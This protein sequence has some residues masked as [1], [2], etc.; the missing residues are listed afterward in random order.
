MR[1]E[2]NKALGSYN[3]MLKIKQT[4]KGLEA[5]LEKSSW[6]WNEDSRKQENRRR[7]EMKRI[8]LGNQVSQ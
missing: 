6:N 3:S 7:L 4:V 1:A 2:N 5:K 8:H